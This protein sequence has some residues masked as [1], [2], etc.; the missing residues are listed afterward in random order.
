MYPKFGGGILLNSEGLRPRRSISNPPPAI[1]SGWLS[2]S[3]FLTSVA[4]TLLLKQIFLRPR[5]GCCDWILNELQGTAICPLY[6]RQKIR[7]NRL[8]GLLLNHIAVKY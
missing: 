1:N 3:L 4:L 8:V 5:P 2:S 6:V 7:N